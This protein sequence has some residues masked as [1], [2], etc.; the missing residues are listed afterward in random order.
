MEVPMT[1]TVRDK[2]ESSN[3]IEDATHFCLGVFPIPTHVYLEKIG[4]E[5]VMRANSKSS[6]NPNYLCGESTWTT[7]FGTET[8]FDTREQALQVFQ[9]YLAR[10]NPN[11]EPNI[12]NS[13]LTEI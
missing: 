8:T 9:N 2:F 6:V 4:N 1:T 11:I 13:N 12:L 10:L 5:W 7:K 3:L